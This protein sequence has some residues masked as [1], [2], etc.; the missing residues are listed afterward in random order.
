MLLNCGSGCSPN[1]HYLVDLPSRCETPAAASSWD[2][3]KVVLEASAAGVLLILSAPL[4]LLV[5]TVV[6]LTSP[7][8]VIYSQVRVGRNGRNFLIHKIRTMTHNCEMISGPRWSSGKDHRVTPVGRVLR[9]LHLDEFPQ[10]WNV[11]RGEMSLIGPRPE[12]PEFVS[13]L[14]KVIPRYRERLGVRPGITGLAQ[15]QLPPDT[16]LAS[17]QRKVACDLLYINQA[18]FWLDLRILAGTAMI[19]FHARLS[20]TR[21]LLRLP[22]GQDQEDPSPGPAVEMAAGARLLAS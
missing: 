9:K 16:D 6:K 11:I 5:M 8:P 1:H 18:N 12:R 14:E 20:L 3:G 15:I 2:C 7:G 13:Q 19:L 4:I 21:R 10:L 17:V 22:S